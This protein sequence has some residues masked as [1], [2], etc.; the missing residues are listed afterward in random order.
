MI[1]AYS[2]ALYA[3]TQQYSTPFGE[4]LIAADDLGITGLWFTGQKHFPS[5]L[6]CASGTN[7][8][9]EAAM[10]WLDQY[11]RGQLPSISVPLHPFGTPFQKA[12]WDILCAIPYGQTVS[13]GQIA[14]QLSPTMSAQAVGNAVA[15]NPISILIPCH[16]VIGS[17][18]SLTGYAGGLTRKGKLLQLEQQRQHGSQ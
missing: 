8:H 4:V 2:Q 17:D 11:F 12:V 13:Y 14:K 7:A 5:H 9:L 3:C 10:V 16:R 6:K 18:G 15:R 1:K